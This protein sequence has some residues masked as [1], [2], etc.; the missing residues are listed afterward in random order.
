MERV[1]GALQGAVLRFSGG[2]QGG[3]NRITRGPDNALYLGEIG[4]PP[5]WGEIGK[6][7]HGLER[8]TYRGAPAYE[9]LE[10]RATPAG[11]DLVLTKPLASDQQVQSTDL[12]AMQW[13]YYPTELYGGP[14]IDPTELSVHSLRLSEDRRTLHADIPDLKAGYV[15]YLALDRRLRSASGEKLWAHE[16]WY[17]LNAIPGVNK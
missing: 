4:N 10:V 16:A 15:V 14:K 8:L 12:R 6:A 5:N 2:F 17:T 13:F 9:L 11:F 1:N 7:W 3:V